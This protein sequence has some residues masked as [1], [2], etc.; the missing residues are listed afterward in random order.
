MSKRLI[1]LLCVACLPGLT[2]ASSDA[3]ARYQSIKEQKRDQYR[4]S[5]P[6]YDP[7]TDTWASQQPQQ[8]PNEPA[9]T[10]SDDY[11]SYWEEPAESSSSSSSSSGS[12]GGGSTNIWGF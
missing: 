11:N 7:Q 4:L 9:S 5:V 3:W 1:A 2:H 12:G 10:R 8:R 6:K